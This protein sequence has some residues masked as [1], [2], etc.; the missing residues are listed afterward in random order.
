[1][2]RWRPSAASIVVPEAGTEIESATKI[3]KRDSR[4]K[5][6]PKLVTV[7]VTVLVTKSW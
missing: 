5:C 4:I 1:V 7:L 2:R 3:A 6:S